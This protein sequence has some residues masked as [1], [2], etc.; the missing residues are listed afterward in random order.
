M[1]FA[2]PRGVGCGQLANL[3]L[4]GR[5]CLGWAGAGICGGWES[6]LSVLLGLS[7]SLGQGPEFPLYLSQ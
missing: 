1:L 3:F 5:T 7:T 6:W 4:P 2:R